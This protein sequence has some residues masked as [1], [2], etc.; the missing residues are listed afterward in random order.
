MAL[1]EAYITR[2]KQAALSGGYRSVIADSEAAA[3]L[4][5]ERASL[6]SDLGWL[7][8]GCPLVELRNG[9]QALVHATRALRADGVERS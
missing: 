1:T 4:S 7:L 5:P 3:V 9:P 6:F 2:G 8:V